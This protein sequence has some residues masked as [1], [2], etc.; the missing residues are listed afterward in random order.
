[1]ETIQLREADLMSDAEVDALRGQYLFAP[2]YDRVIRDTATVLKPDGSVLAVYIADAVSRAARQ[3]AFAVKD[4]IGRTDARGYAAGGRSYRKRL[5]NGTMSNTVRWRRMNSDVVG[6]LDR[7]PRNPYCRMTTLTRDHA[8][9]DAVLPL[10]VEVDRVFQQLAPKRW[11]AQRRFIDR[12]PLDFVVPDTVFTSVTVNKNE[13]TAAHTDEH[14]YSDGLGVMTVLEGG[15]YDGGEL[16][17]PKYRTAV[18]MRTGG[19]CLADVHELHGNARFVGRTFTRL[20]FV[21]YA[22]EHMDQCGTVEQ[23][24]EHMARRWSDE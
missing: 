9:L 17:F 13:R 11:G 21:F 4:K 16:V 14:D 6:F 5:A 1:M 2:H 15:H 7:D 3:S 23:E 10:A 18:D 19:V 22:R 8:A 20:S 12:V 24:R